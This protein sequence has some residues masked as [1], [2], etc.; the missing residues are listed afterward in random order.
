MTKIEDIAK[1]HY[2]PLPYHNFQHA[3]A[4]RKYALKLV[5]RCKKYH[6]PVDQEVVEIAALFH[7]AGYEKVKN[8]KEEYSCQIAKQELS[9]LKYSKKIITQV[10]K[11]ILATKPDYPLKTNEQKILR[12]AD[13]SSFAASYQQFYN[14]S[15]KIEKEYR[16]LNKRN[17]FPLKSWLQSVKLY[18]RPKIILTPEYTKDHWQAKAQ[19]N[20]NRFLQDMN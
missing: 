9:K 17:K 15:K 16:L 6:I 8:K 13:L 18:M 11:T 2:S 19:K 10:K 1:K 12:A 14:N 20:I 3:L 4:V 5:R 7:D